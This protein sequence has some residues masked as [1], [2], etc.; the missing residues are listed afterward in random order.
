MIETIERLGDD[1]ELDFDVCIVGA[2]AAG[3]S[4]AAKLQT[5]GLKICVLEAGRREIDEEAQ[6]LFKGEVV[7]EPI[8]VE[9]GRFRVFGGATRR[10]T[11]RCAELDPHDFEPRDWVADSGWPIGLADL[12]P[13]Y[14]EAQAVCGFARAWRPDNQIPVFRQATKLLTLRDA[15]PFLWRY[16]AVSWRAYQDWGRRFEGQLAAARNATVILGAEV[17]GAEGV[18]ALGV[19]SRLKVRKPDGSIVHVSARRFVLSCGGLENIR[20]LLNLCADRNSGMS[21][22][23]DVL[24]RWFMQHPRAVTARGRTSGR[25]CDLLRVASVRRGDHYEVGFA[26]DPDLQASE[27]L[28]NASAILRYQAE[29]DSGW[30][31]IKRWSKQG[32]TPSWRDVRL[33]VRDAPLI[34]SNTVRRAAGRSALAR[35]PLAELVVD[36][37]QAPD[38]DSRITLSRKTDRLGLRCLR[39]DWRI[40]PQDRRTSTVFT[41]GLVEELR[42]LGLADLAPVAGLAETGALSAEHM[43][44]SYHHLGGAR[45]SAEPSQGV[46]DA[47]LRVHAC[48][49]LYVVGGSVMPTGGHANPTFTI[50]A[51]ALRLG[52]HL[53]ARARA[54]ER[55][56]VETTPSADELVSATAP[57]QGVLA[58]VRS[59]LRRRAPLAG[60][61][62]AQT[63]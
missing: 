32:V 47:D 41:L 9:E 61:S 3:L 2:G 26:L 51:L 4:L 29:P 17:V 27:G 14:R 10:W 54:D 59:M 42:R 21:D 12:K 31:V 30:E 58:T 1:A 19:I 5:A 39:V 57:V 18:R 8:A 23:H 35:R 6:S 16:A 55:A 22:P 44:E 46:V 53:I 43:L 50:V 49:N 34:A 7:G 36:L 20:L 13:Y 33:L 48:A 62:S 11:G 40:G 25:I 37:E 28:L 15:K 52:D 24:G 38:R 45:M 56:P 60:P 63:A